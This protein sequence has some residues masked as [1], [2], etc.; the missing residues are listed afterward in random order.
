LL[1][2]RWSSAPCSPAFGIF[3]AN[4]KIVALTYRDRGTSNTQLE[5]LSGD[6]VIAFLWKNVLS[7]M[8]GRGANWC[9]TFHSGPTKGQRA[10]GSANTIDAAKA[11]IES[12]WRGWLNA[13]GLIERP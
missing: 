4:E 3:S 13:A 6:E 2:R 12:T 8:A 10:H 5:V 9:W 7:V 1:A 11:E